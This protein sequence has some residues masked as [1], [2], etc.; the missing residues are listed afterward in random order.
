MTTKHTINTTIQAEDNSQFSKDIIDGLN[1][2]PKHLPSKYFYD[3]IG[4]QLFQDIMNCADYY[5]T[6]CEMEIFKTQTP[7]LA[8]LIKN[9]GNKFELIEMGA[10]DATKSIHLLKRLLDEG[11]DFTYMP[12]DISENIIRHLETTLPETLPNLKFSGLNGEYFDMLEKACAKSS[13]PKV[14]L[15]LGSNIGNMLPKDAAE[16]CAHLRSYISPGD[17]VI[18]GFDLKK[19]PRII[20][21][22]YDDKEGITRRFN[23]N[24]LTRIN[25][26]LATNFEINHFD[27]YCSYDPETGA[28]KSYLVAL[29]DMDVHFSDQTIHFKKDEYI[30][31]EISQKYTLDQIDE[32]GY[33]AG[34][35]TIDHL[36]DQ[37]QWFT[38]TIWVAA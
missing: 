14:I 21:S 15:F 29:K 17:M 19:N 22:A 9:V 26:Q 33:D 8:E 23:L 6:G 20:R 7:R 13:L 25:N 32:I 24:L 10:G 4:D 27:H 38:D 36:L 18:M 34:F 5:L 28:C 12:I 37:K 31:M 30:W 2:V 3:N 1:A 35:H 16:F 11:L